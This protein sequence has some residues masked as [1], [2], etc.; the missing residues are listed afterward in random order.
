V[1]T[2]LSLLAGASGFLRP[3]LPLQ[4]LAEASQ[5]HLYRPGDQLLAAGVKAPAALLILDGQVVVNHG[6]GSQTVT[7]ERLGAGDFY[8]AAL[9]P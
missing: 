1:A 3:G 6:T 5:V 8:A 9:A 4:A 7:L 2:R